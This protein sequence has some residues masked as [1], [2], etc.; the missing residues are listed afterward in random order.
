MMGK[1]DSSLL[2]KIQTSAKTMTEEV[3]FAWDDIPGAI[4]GGA[5]FE[6]VAHYFEMPDGR[7]VSIEETARDLGFLDENG[8]LK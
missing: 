3:G 4:A 1:R 7:S 5:L 6:L 2:A 8:D